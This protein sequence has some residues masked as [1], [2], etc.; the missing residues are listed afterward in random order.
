MV[1]SNLP[2]TGL[3]SLSYVD[4]AFFKSESGTKVLK[5]V[6]TY[7]GSEG[8]PSSLP[9]DY[10]IV[11]LNY[12]SSFERGIKDPLKGQDVVVIHLGGKPH[13]YPLSELTSLGSK[14]YSL[15]YAVSK[16]VK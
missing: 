2:S 9:E 16:K 14:L 11:L 8:L 5:T 3:D 7:D 15:G 4:R 12:K 1:A 6:I 10:I 13:L